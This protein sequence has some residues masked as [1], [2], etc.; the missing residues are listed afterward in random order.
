MRNLSL[1][2]AGLAALCGV[3]LQSGTASA[4]PMSGLANAA[5]EMT[6]DVQQVAWVCGPFR[7]FW[8]PSYHRY[9][10]AYAYGGPRAYARPGFGRPYRR[11]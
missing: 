9:Y 5:A 7:C 4:M 3:A 10:G 11:W 8:R 6:A 2:A 1:A